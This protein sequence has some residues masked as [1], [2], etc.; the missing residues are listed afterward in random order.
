MKILLLVLGMTACGYDDRAAPT[1]IRTEE[2]LQLNPST[3]DDKLNGKCV[4]ELLRR[5]SG[6]EN[7]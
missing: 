1:P 2:C 6:N 5:E 3:G 7:E 4:L